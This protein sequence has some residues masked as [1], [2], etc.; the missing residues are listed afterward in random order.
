MCNSGAIFMSGYFAGLLRQCLGILKQGNV[1]GLLFMRQDFIIG[2]LQRLQFYR[3]CETGAVFR[4]VFFVC[5]GGNVISLLC[6]R[7][8]GAML[9]VFYV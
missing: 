4:I 6:I 3:S 1:I 5:H 9:F 7:R 2:I 8:G